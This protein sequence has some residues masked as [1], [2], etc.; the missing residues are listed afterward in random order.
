VIDDRDRA[1]VVAVLGVVAPR[2]AHAAETDGADLW[3]VGAKGAGGEGGVVLESRLLAQGLISAV[4]PSR[5]LRPPQRPVGIPV[6]D[7]EGAV[8]RT[9]L[10]GLAQRTSLLQVVRT[11]R[12]RFPP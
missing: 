5:R 12:G 7:E 1:L 4:S 10:A 6:G 11:P 3:S 9:H 2:H 8:G